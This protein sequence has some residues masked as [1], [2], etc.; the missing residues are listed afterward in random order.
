MPEVLKCDRCGKEYTDKEDIEW[1]KR[2]AEKWKELCRRDGVEP[3][4]VAPCPNISCSGE[5]LVIQ[6]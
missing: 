5:L 4:G 6:R 3:R 1:A 2:S